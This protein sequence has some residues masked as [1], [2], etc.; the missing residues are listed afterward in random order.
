M[1]GYRVGGIK[2][3]KQEKK[4]LLAYVIIRQIKERKNAKNNLSTDILF[5]IWR[6]FV[7]F[8]INIIFSTCCKEFCIFSQ[9]AAYVAKLK[10]LKIH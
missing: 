10:T 8:I 3:E 5:K 9:K 1:V 4:N 7:M 6:F 2:N